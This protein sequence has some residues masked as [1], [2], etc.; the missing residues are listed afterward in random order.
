MR[1]AANM[2]VDIDSIIKHV[3][4]GL[5]D[6]TATTINPMAFGF[7]P[8]DQAL[9]AGPGPG[10]EAPRRGRL[11]ERPRGRLPARTQ[12]AVEPGGHPD[13]RRHR[14]RPRQG[15]HPDQA[16]HGRRDR[17][18]HEPGPRQQGRPDVRVVVGLLL[19]LR[20]RR[21]PLRRDDVQPAVQLL[22]QQGAGRPRHP[23]PL[24]ARRQEAA[25]RSTPRRRSSSTTTPPTSSSGACA[26]SGASA[27]GSSTRRRGTRSTG[28]SP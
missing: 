15:R 12:P 9:Q 11:P 18:L 23:G 16:A 21:D 3:I 5:G 27:T 10:Q 25:R 14:R 7:D 24:H 20:R 8:I 6:R 22:L 4:N 13:V 19:G 17:A 1:Q 2:A 26:A 28:C